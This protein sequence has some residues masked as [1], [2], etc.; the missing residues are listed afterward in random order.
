MWL[1]RQVDRVLSHLEARMVLVDV[2]ASGQP[3][4]E[5]ASLRAHATY[6][7]F[8]PDRRE[9]LK[10]AD[11]KGG[12]LIV[13]NKA[14]TASAAARSVRFYFTKNPYCSSTCRP[15]S[16]KLK[17]YLFYPRFEVVREG[18][19]A[20]TT[21]ETATAEIGLPRIDWLKL[22]TQGTDLR[23]YDSLAPQLR[24]TVLIID[25]EPGLDEWYVGEDVFAKV[26]SRLLEEGYWLSDLS[27]GGAPKVRSEALVIKAGKKGFRH[28]VYEHT[29]KRNP[30]YANARY[31]RSIEF[32]SRTDVSHE[33]LVYAWAGAMVTDNSGFALDIAKLYSTRFPACSRGEVLQRIAFRAVRNTLVLRSYRLL[34]HLSLNKLRRVIRGTY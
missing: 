34:R 15:N 19:V 22:D 26:H 30:M 25:I 8:D 21:L 6:V 23:I 20:T 27:V 10:V 9:V 7:G 32:L 4:R 28:L 31:F 1:K 33:Q 17:E 13:L 14:V 11:G 2:G 24:N 3:P 5:W 16:Q 29:L 12:Y 18:E